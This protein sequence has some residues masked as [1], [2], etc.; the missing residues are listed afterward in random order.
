MK[1]LCTLAML[2]M[3]S[4]AFA[5]TCE[6]VWKNDLVTLTAVDAPRSRVFEE[7]ARVTGIKVTGAEK[8]KGTVSIQL[9]SAD[10]HVALRQLVGDASYTLVDLLPAKRG[11]ASQVQISILDSSKG[12]PA[13]DI[14]K[15]TPSAVALVQNPDT[16]AMEAQLLPPAPISN[17]PSRPTRGVI[18]PPQPGPTVRIDDEG[19]D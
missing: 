17:A 9:R 6:V 5:S 2:P 10:L 18:P 13:H 8:L 16:G 14:M 7:V 4:A 3:L 19:P 15:S 1:W 11:G 12:Y